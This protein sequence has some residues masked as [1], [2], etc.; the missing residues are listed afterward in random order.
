MTVEKDMRNR[1]N[2]KER[3]SRRPPSRPRRRVGL[4]FDQAPRCEQNLADQ[5]GD[6]SNWS[7]DKPVKID[8]V[9][10]GIAMAGEASPI[11]RIGR[12]KLLDERVKSWDRLEGPTRSVPSKIDAQL[13]R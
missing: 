10:R 8:I 9:Q 4:L 12:E 2:E 1:R 7:C 3:N 6:D 13:T 11:S 5:S